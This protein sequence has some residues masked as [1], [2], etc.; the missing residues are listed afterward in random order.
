L[1]TAAG[2]GLAGAACMRFSRG[3]HSHHV[4]GG[5]GD[6]LAQLSRHSHG[7]MHR[8]PV[9]S[10]RG[11]GIMR[12]L[13][14]HTVLCAVQA[15]VVRA[16]RRV[17][18]CAADEEWSSTPLRVCAR[19]PLLLAVVTCISICLCRRPTNTIPTTVTTTINTLCLNLGKPLLRKGAGE[20][21]RGGGHLRAGAAGCRCR[22]GMVV[23][24]LRAPP[25]IFARPR[26][27]WLL[28]HL[29]LC[30]HRVRCSMRARRMGADAL[31]MS[32]WGCGV[33][34]QEGRRLGGV[35]GEGFGDRLAVGGSR[36]H[37]GLW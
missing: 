37:S 10:S 15:L 7:H 27:A 3:D 35:E 18:Q 25:H 30:K 22:G 2:E 9:V 8:G 12:C 33:I 13:L 29:C 23:A 24:E 16:R 11:W 36:E 17:P 21:G 26:S 28:A 1:D 19:N 4:H 5:R 14:V 6:I 34:R 31:L 20:D 32:F